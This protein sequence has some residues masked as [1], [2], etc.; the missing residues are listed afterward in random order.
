MALAVRFAIIIGSLFSTS[1]LFA[2][3]P[4]DKI[5][6]KHGSWIDAE[7]IR[8]PDTPENKPFVVFKS[9]SGGLFKLKKGRAYDATI[10]ADSVTAEYQRRLA[11]M[12][13]RVENADDHWDLYEYC[14]ANDNRFQREMKYHL[15]RII[16]LDPKDTEARKLLGYE[17]RVNGQWYLKDQQFAVHGY[18]KVA[19][20]WLPE[21]YLAFRN[22][23]EAWDDARSAGQKALKQWERAY[24]N[25]DPLDAERAL[26]TIASPPV[27]ELL[28][29]KANSAKT[30]SEMMMFM[31]A[32]G[33]VESPVAMNALI[34]L[35]ISHNSQAIREHAAVLLKQKHFPA[36]NVNAN[37]V[38]FLSS[39]NNFYINRAA[40]IIRDLDQFSA[41]MPL[42]NSLNTVHE[43][44]NPNAQQPGGINAG[45]NNNG[46][47]GLNMGG[48]GPANKRV[49]AKNSDVLGALKNLTGVDFQYD[50][51]RWKNWY[52]S[53]T[54]LQDAN[55][56]YDD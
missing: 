15:N 48:G 39:P 55:L 40:R 28:L 1:I 3:Q 23:N 43:F 44:K 34:P 50:T 22:G 38:P 21:S 51:Q 8:L 19:G 32:I 17:N 12:E 2:Q 31:N 35:A 53:E 52:I 13:S 18:V 47:A 27:V 29:K 41:V 42:I 46:Q 16:K 26:K 11:A 6:T 10:L 54:T 37:L 4:A 49:N 30:A 25:A 9:E 33:S 24:R 5:K 7:V 45:F 20:D 14:R 56:Q 36:K